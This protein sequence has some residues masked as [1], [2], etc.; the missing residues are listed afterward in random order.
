MINMQR[1]SRIQFVDLDMS[2]DEEGAGSVL[3]SKHE[4]RTRLGWCY[5]I[6]V[7]EVKQG[8][9]K[10]DAAEDVTKGQTQ[11][12]PNL[13]AEGMVE[14]EDILEEELVKSQLLIQLTMV[15]K[16]TKAV[17]NLE[18]EIRNEK[19]LKVPAINLILRIQSALDECD[20]FPENS[21]VDILDIINM[22]PD[23]S[24]VAWKE[25]LGGG[26][27]LDRSNCE[28]KTLPQSVTE[29]SDTKDQ[30][31]KQKEK[32]VWITQKCAKILQNAS[33]MYN[34]AARTAVGLADLAGMC[35]SEKDFRDMMN[36]VFGLPA[37]IQQ[38]AE[39]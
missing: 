18:N 31:R 6:R 24:A 27:E 8:L 3:I 22:I 17:E 33:R 19:S 13:T 7:Q 11:D 2:F 9:M 25:R 16:L 39:A 26:T 34:Y 35:D 4:M 38:Q 12:Q 21:T 28:M 30:K 37:M 5:T 20:L 1:M 14:D 15:E 29:E 32:D 10:T 36:V 23:K